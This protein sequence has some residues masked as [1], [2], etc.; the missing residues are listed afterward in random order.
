MAESTQD[1]EFAG[2]IVDLLQGIGPVYAKRMFGG[3][4]VFLEGLM[5]G[6]ISNRELYLK[7]DAQTRHDFELSG[8]EAFTYH[9]QGKPMQLAYFQ[10]PEEALESPQVMVEWGNRAY[11]VA[12]R[13]AASKATNGRRQR[14]G[15]RK[16]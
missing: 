16:Q 4:G 13:A 2:Y 6:L 7:V 12:L 14:A 9:K 15:S 11:G 3:Y 8:L 10:A 5:F 1:K